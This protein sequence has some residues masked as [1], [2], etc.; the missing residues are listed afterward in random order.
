MKNVLL[1]LEY[2]LNTPISPGDRKRSKNKN[3]QY[4]Y[5]LDN[6]KYNKNTIIYSMISLYFDTDDRMQ[7]IKKYEEGKLKPYELLGDHRY[8]EGIHKERGMLMFSVG[9]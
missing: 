9:S 2:G 3:K 6:D 8:F 7:L 4:S 1:A 5:T